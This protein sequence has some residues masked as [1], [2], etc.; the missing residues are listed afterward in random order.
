MNSPSF[1]DSEELSV[2]DSC[3]S[4][5]TKR[6]CLSSAAMRLLASLF[7][8]PCSRAVQAALICSSR[9]MPPLSGTFNATCSWLLGSKTCSACPVFFLA[10]IVLIFGLCVTGDDSVHPRYVKLFE[11]IA[12]NIA[13][14]FIIILSDMSVA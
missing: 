11:F 7:F 1:Y 2:S 3:F 6:E 14:N 9:L 12:R 13:C 10:I 8:V 5:N 4:S